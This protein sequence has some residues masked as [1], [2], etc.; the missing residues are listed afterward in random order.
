MQPLWESGRRLLNP[1]PFTPCITEQ[2]PRRTAG[3]R[4]LRNPTSFKTLP[5]SSPRSGPAGL[6]HATLKGCWQMSVGA[7]GSRITVP[8]DIINVQEYCRGLETGA[9][10]ETMMKTCFVLHVCFPRPSLPPSPPPPSR[11]A[12]RQGWCWLC[13]WCLFDFTLAP[14]LSV[15]ASSL[16][17]LMCKFVCRRS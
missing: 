4:G 7:G 3:R 10:G 1:D 12:L 2:R 6:P 14:G 16:A 13:A 17:L 8:E 11:C 9:P 15:L 5:R